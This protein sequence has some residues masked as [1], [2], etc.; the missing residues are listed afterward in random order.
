MVEPVC[1]GVLWYSLSLTCPQQVYLNIWSL[2]VSFLGDYG[3]FGT[4]GLAGRLRPPGLAFGTDS[5]GHFWARSLVTKMWRSCL[6]PSPYD[7]ALPAATLSNHE[8]HLWTCEPNPWA[9]P[10]L[11]CFCPVFQSRDERSTVTNVVIGFPDESKDSAL[12]KLDGNTYL[13][14]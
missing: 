8:G 5:P 13:V 14:T 1:P 11:R 3:T 4:C 12:N 9:S 2:G 7:G 6:T 10:S